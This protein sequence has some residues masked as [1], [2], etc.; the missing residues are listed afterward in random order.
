MTDGGAKGAMVAMMRLGT[1]WAPCNS[2]LVTTVIR[3]EWGFTGYTLT[4]FCGMT[5]WPFSNFAKAVLAG[6]D[7][8]LSTES[9]DD[10]DNTLKKVES[11]PNS[12]DAALHKA[13]KNILYM[14][15]NSSAMYT[16]AH[17]GKDREDN[18]RVEDMVPTEEA[19]E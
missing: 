17:S 4:D 12:W 1:D 3:D 15:A 10:F 8:L 14:V 5:V 9:Q 13:S 2:S 16:D 18:V 7:C 6:T 11:V 19:A